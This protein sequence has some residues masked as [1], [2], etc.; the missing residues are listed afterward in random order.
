MALEFKAEALLAAQDIRVAFFDVDGVLTDGGVYFSE[1][2]ETLKR[3]SILDGYGLKLLR[4]A[5]ITP[6][7][8]TGRDSKPLRVR[9]QAL[10][11]EHVRYGTED[12]LPAAE[13]L[14]ALLGFDWKQAAA[15]G[16]DWPDL[17]VLTRAAFTE[18]EIKVLRGVV[19]SLDYF[20]PKEPRGAGYP[21]RKARDDEA[22]RSGNRGADGEEDAGNG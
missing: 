11:I 4:A 17:P 16:D 6:A 2:G 22:A 3:F 15:I 9:L 19:S 20:S 8:I 1:H 18:A 5:G 14:L 10:G 7:V 12:K 13:A 21:E